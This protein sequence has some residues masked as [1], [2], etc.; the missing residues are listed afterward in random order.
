MYFALSIKLSLPQ[1]PED[2]EGQL[3]S[4]AFFLIQHPEQNHWRKGKLPIITDS[5]LLVAMVSRTDIKKNVEFPHATK[6]KRRQRGSGS[7]RIIQKKTS[8]Q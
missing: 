1:K 8:G 4:S 7:L 5:G 3:T 6:A 2:A